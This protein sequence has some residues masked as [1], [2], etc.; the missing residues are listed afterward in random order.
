MQSRGKSMT[1]V[2]IKQLKAST[3]QKSGTIAVKDNA[4]W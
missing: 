3:W 2:S 4:G 1:S